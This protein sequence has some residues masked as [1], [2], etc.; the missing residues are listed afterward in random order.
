EL[1]RDVA[2][3]ANQQLGDLVVV[4]EPSLEVVLPGPVR[5]RATSW[6]V[7]FAG[8]RACVAAELREPLLKVR[9]ELA[10][11]IEQRVVANE[12]R[13]VPNLEQPGELCRRIRVI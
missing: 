11:R 9:D 7:V 3:L 13:V 10:G 6:V 1:R 4:A 8:Y 2:D 5:E 12:H